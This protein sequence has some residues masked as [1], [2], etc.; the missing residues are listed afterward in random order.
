MA[1]EIISWS[2]SKKIWDRAGLKLMNPGSSVRHVTDCATL[3][4]KMRV[5]QSKLGPAVRL[6]LDL[7]RVRT[8]KFE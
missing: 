2:L 4:L 3:P 6:A 1:I 7:N 5:F 8:G